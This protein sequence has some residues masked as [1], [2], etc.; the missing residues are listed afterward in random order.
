MKVVAAFLPEDLSKA[1]VDLEQG[2]VVY[3][4]KAVDAHD[5]KKKIKLDEIVLPG[6]G[7]LFFK[8]IGKRV[9]VACN[10]EPRTFAKDLVS[11][12]MILAAGPSDALALATVSKDVPAGTRIK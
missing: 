8:L 4:R 7:F 3:I 6:K 11:Y 10:L 5:L 1:T 2:I 9:I 12:G